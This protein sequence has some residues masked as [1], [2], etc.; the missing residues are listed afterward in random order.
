MARFIFNIKENPN[1][2]LNRALREYQDSRKYPDRLTVSSLESY[3]KNK[4]FKRVVA[5]SDN[6]RVKPP[7]HITLYVGGVG[8]G[9]QV[10]I[11]I[12]DV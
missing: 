4:G 3:L 7:T 2:R 10:K 11:E 12:T 5:G 1:E 8:Q 9:C 6:T